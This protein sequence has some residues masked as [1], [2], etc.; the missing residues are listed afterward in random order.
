MALTS[1]PAAQAKVR[2]TYP[3][4]AAPPSQP[5]RMEPRL[6]GVIPRRRDRK[7]A[8]RRRSLQRWARAE[9]DTL[10]HLL[11]E[12]PP[13]PTHGMPASGWP[14]GFHPTSAAP[15]L[16]R[17]SMIP[18][19]PVVHHHRR[20]FGPQFVDVMEMRSAAEGYRPGTTSHACAHQ[21]RCPEGSRGASAARRHSPARR[22]HR[23]RI[24]SRS[25]VTRRLPVR[26]VGQ[27]LV[28]CQN[29]RG[30]RAF[31]VPMSAP[32]CASIA[33]N[34]GAIRL[35]TKRMTSFSLY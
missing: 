15:A 35:A 30:W 29:R 27:V 9:A 34:A 26:E 19:R 6:A 31:P 14:P 8:E 4:A 32:R 20:H 10:Q 7:P 25:T 3:M 16:D 13:G 23:S 33:W 5:D 2:Q 21:A 17:R 11:K 1:Q 28:T 18:F 22:S 12:L 24:G